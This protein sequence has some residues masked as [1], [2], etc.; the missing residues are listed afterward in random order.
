MHGLARAAGGQFLLRIED[1]DQSRCRAEFVD[2]IM[3]DLRWLGLEWDGPVM[4]QSERLDVYRA[5][6]VAL[7][8]QGL[9]YRCWCTRAEIAASVGAPQGDEGPI[10]PGTCK[11][12]ADTGDGRPYCWRLD[13]QK[14]G[15]LP[16]GDVVLA[17]KDTPTSYHL[18]ATIDDA[19]QGITDVI[20]GN[21]LRE[22]THVHRKLQSLL[23]LPTPRYHYHALLAGPDGT[24]LAKRHQAPTIQSLR[25]S[26][27]EPLRLIDGMRQ[28]RFPVGFK[29]IEA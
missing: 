10:Y 11:E 13:T 19:A 7:I 21:D 28:G 8:E 29:L 25:E 5:T 27:T 2:G 26:G 20:R 18:S 9:V 14:A 1:I 12:R 23:N 3:E 17:R 22:A 4:I 16:Q 24:R 6:L 15:D